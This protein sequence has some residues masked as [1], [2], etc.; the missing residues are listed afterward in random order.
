MAIMVD[1]AEG[2]AGVGKREAETAYETSIS[3][4]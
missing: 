3:R 2:F 1:D 4:M